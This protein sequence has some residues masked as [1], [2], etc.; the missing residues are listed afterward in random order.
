MID[1]M[2]FE[3]VSKGGEFISVAD[4]HVWVLISIEFGRGKIA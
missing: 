4:I 1:T 2:P 3:P